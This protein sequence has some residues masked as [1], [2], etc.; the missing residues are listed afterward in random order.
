MDSILK[1]PS[2]LT[3]GGEKRELTILFS[4]IRGFT[5]FSEKMDAKALSSLLNEYLGVMTKII[6]AHEGTLDKYIGDAIMAFWGAPLDQPKHAANSLKTAIAMMK[7]LNEQR[8]L[9]QEKY[10]VQIEIGIGINS[11]MV[12]VGNMGSETNFAYTVI[13]DHVNLASRLESLTKAYGVTILTTRFTLNDVLQAGEPLPPHRVLDHVKV[14]G[15]KNAVEMIQVLDRE[16]DSEGLKMFEEGR[17]LYTAQKWDE[18][19]TVFTAANARLALSVDK[20]DGPCAVY[21]E[22]CGDFKKVPPEAGWDGSW[23]MHSK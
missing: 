23:E 21:L 22:R 2:K 19:I 14:K 4:D 3:V 10:G 9:I 6:F 18:A 16:Y 7:A 1:D 13:G 8:P 11:G 20:M 5:S 17:A 12:S 15:K